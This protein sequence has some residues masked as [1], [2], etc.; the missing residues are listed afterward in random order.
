MSDLSRTFEPPS[1]PREERIKQPYIPEFDGL[2]ALSIL[3]VITV[4]MHDRVWRFLWGQYGVTIFFVLS[5]YLITMLALREEGKRGRVSLKAFFTRRCFRIFPLY[6]AVLGLYALLIF[7]VGMSPLKR[8]SF[9][10]SLPYFLFYFQEIPFFYDIIPAGSEPVFGQTWSLG[11]EEKF[12]LVWPILMF[13]PL[14]LIKRVRGV[15]CAALAV[16]FAAGPLFNHAGTGRMVFSYYHIAI[17]GMLAF[18]SHDPAGAA[19]L[20]RLRNNLAG[21]AIVAITLALQLSRS[22]LE[23]YYLAY[24]VDVL[25]SIAIAALIAHVLFGENAFIRFLGARPLVWIGKLSYGMYLVHMLVITGCDKIIKPGSGRPELW[26]L[27]YLAAVA[28][29][30][31]LAWVFAVV[32]ERPLIRVGRDL[33]RRFLDRASE[34]KVSGQTEL[35]PHVV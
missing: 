35:A 4:H 8:P 16:G 22:H 29:S 15:G 25:Y 12:Y 3:V 34:R 28:G 32:L 20:R 14:G 33:S 26:V 31:C 18:V 7:V 1:S 17:G 9:E 21:A 24:G 27:A 10:I 11:I 30:C 19:M 6:Y 5:G 23:N 13:G 2:R